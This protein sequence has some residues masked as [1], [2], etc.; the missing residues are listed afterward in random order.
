MTNNKKLLSDL[1][2]KEKR[3]RNEEEELESDNGVMT[4]T[5]LTVMKGRLL[6]RVVDLRNLQRA[7]MILTA[8]AVNQQIAILKTRPL[9]SLI[10]LANIVRDLM[11][12]KQRFCD[13]PNALGTIPT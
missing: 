12:T 4:V 11:F 3:Y 7:K 10:F 1:L 9:F 5:R 6:R 2:E 8:A 13:A